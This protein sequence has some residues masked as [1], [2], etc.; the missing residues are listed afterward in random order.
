MEYIKNNLSFVKNKFCYIAGSLFGV[1]SIVLSLFSWD[2]MGISSKCQ[3]FFICVGVILISFAASV[4]YL[5]LKRKNVLWEQ[6]E[7]GIRAV[8]TDIFKIASNRKFEKII[9]IPV[10]TTFDTVVGDGIVSPCSVHGRWIKWYCTEENTISR[11]DELIQCDLSARK[12]TP[13]RFQSKNE[14]PKGKQTMYQRGTIAVIDDDKTLYYLLALSHFD[15][16]MNAQCS[17]AELLGVIVDMIDF[18]NK[19]GQ[20]LPIY[21]PLLGTG[22]SRA[23]VTPSESLQIITDLLKL[24]R[25]KIQGEANVVVYSKIKNQVSIFDL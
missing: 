4:I 20:G 11:L 25:D 22:I 18:Y 23:N 13:M 15:E 17:K 24:N 16:N 7:K 5:C 21:I 1:L 8:Y 10:N 14:K 12:V 19:N 6:G 3:R 9:V 2:E